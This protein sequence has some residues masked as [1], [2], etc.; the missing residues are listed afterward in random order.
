MLGWRLPASPNT[1][2]WIGIGTLA[3]LLLV[4]TIVMRVAMEFLPE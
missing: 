1:R 2:M 3:T 4:R